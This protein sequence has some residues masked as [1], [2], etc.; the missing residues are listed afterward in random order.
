M[1]QVVPVHARGR[2]SAIQAAAIHAAA[3]DGG[4]TGS[5]R[6]MVPR[7]APP[8]PVLQARPGC[9]GY[10]DK[11]QAQHPGLR[12]CDQGAMGWGGAGAC[13]AGG[14][15]GDS[16]LQSSNTCTPNMHVSAVQM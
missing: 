11:D 16:P 8:P 12:S 14:V 5:G 10:P 15:G 9:Q 3:V 7:P 1:H 2:P 6:R 4:G 13:A